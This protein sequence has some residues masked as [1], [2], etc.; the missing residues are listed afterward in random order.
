MCSS[1]GH[2]RV[3]PGARNNKPVP[4]FLWQETYLKGGE[5]Y[6]EW[7]THSQGRRQASSTQGRIISLLD[8]E[9]KKKKACLLIPVAIQR[10]PLG[11]GWNSF[12]DR[13]AS[14]SLRKAASHV[15]PSGEPLLQRF[16]SLNDTASWE[17]GRLQPPTGR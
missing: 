5:S 7:Y 9:R 2:P 17:Q 6:E 10:V 8:I 13:D 14:L 1:A 11:P 3:L 16:T 4:Q 12:P 15:C